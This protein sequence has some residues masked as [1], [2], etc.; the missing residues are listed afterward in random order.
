MGTAICDDA[1]GVRSNKN[2]DPINTNGA[3]NKENSKNLVKGWSFALQ[4]QLCIDIFT[5]LAFGSHLGTHGQCNPMSF[6]GR[7]HVH[8]L[9]LY[10]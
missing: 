1:A 3:S 6:I 4:G 7:L 9:S 5:S 2:K 10:L 8:I